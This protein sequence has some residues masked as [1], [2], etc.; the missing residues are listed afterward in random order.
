MFRCGSNNVDVVAAI[1]Q[2]YRT[3]FEPLFGGFDE[4]QRREIQE[5]QG[6]KHSKL[7]I[8]GQAALNS[9]PNSRGMSATQW[10]LFKASERPLANPTGADKVDRNSDKR[11]ESDSYEENDLAKPS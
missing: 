11:Q 4:S 1:T 10:S 5:P 3:R 6:T 8:A 2:H 9:R 7:N